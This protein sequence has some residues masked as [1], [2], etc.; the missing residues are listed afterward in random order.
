MQAFENYFWREKFIRYPGTPMP[1][2]LGYRYQCVMQ[3]EK[4]G[5]PIGLK[6]VQRRFSN[7]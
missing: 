6:D 5:C 1:A 2:L 3:L 7:C 4:I